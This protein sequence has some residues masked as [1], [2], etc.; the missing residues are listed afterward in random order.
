MPRNLPKTDVSFSAVTFG[1][2]AGGGWDWGGCDDE[3]TIR[4]IHAALD[5]G[6][7]SIDTAPVYG[8]GH[9]E[10]VVGK[11]IEGRRDKVTLATKCGFR[12][13]ITE[14]QLMQKKVPDGTLVD[15]RRCLKRDSIL[16]E[17]E[18]SLR[19]LKTDYIDLYQCHAPDPDTPLEETMETLADLRSQGKIRAFGVSN[20]S[21]D[22][23]RRCSEIGP[24]ASTQSMYN[25]IL[26]DIESDLLPYCRENGIGVL[27][28]TSILLGLLSGKVAPEREFP[29][30]DLR[31]GH[32]LFTPEWRQAVMEMLS[33]LEPIREKYRCTFAQLAIAW[34]V[35]TPGVTT[36]L[37][38][39]RDEK[40]AVENAKAGSI[41]LSREE[42]ELMRRASDEVRS[43]MFGI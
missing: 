22:Q 39:A 21:L 37:V 28:Y 38:G 12:W 9:S 16:F 33:G 5:H 41:T 11:A 1:A 6:T 25:M 13:G 18:E 15:I 34:V 27:T 3:M 26:R 40:Q 42:Y 10:E 2:W 32:H 20:F 19:R 35:A 24:V 17:V 31:R 23:V 43:R 8:G 4:A 29:E 36:A 30:G 14:G 7:T